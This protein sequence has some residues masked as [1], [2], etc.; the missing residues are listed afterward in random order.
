MGLKIDKPN[1]YLTHL[2]G[3]PKSFSVK[4]ATGTTQVTHET[5]SKGG[6]KHSLV[7]HDQSETVHEGEVIPPDKLCTITVGGGQT[8]PDGNYGS[9]KIHVSL[10]LPCHRDHLNEGYEFATDWVSEKIQEAVAMAKGH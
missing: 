2:S 6:P 9:V 5:G 4:Q 3:V 10:A 1:P 8:I 7:M